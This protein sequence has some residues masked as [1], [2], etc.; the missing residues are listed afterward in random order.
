[1]HASLDRLMAYI[2][3]QR[4]E[5][6]AGQS[7]LFGGPRA[8]ELVLDELPDWSLETKLWYE[9]KVLGT[10]VSGHPVTAYEPKFA[11]KITHHFGDVRDLPY[12]DWPTMQP[13]VLAGLVEK[14]YENRTNL[15]VRMSDATG[16]AEIQFYRDDAERARWVLQ[17]NIIIA[18]KCRLR[19][20]D[21]WAGVTGQRAHKIGVFS[22][23]AG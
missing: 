23:S 14:V 4:E 20:D 12:S 11:S 1:M 10:F 3:A 5:T 19:K 2:K 22:P 17:P 8:N 21:G 6:A 18:V 15:S 16:S 13:V 9:R 7:D